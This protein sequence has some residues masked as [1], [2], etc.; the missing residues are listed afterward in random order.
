MTLFMTLDGV[1]FAM[2]L[3]S[4]AIR[5]TI[6]REFA[7]FSSLGEEPMIRCG[8]FRVL[9]LPSTPSILSVRATTFNGYKHLGVNSHFSPQHSPFLGA[10]KADVNPRRCN[11]QRR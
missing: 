9:L 10:S 7:D 11:F 6:L 2:R 1:Q 3:A 5:E 4:S 8:S